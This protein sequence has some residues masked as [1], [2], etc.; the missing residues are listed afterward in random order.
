MQWGGKPRLWNLMVAEATWCFTVP[1]SL[2]LCVLKWFV[3]RMKSFKVCSHINSD[4][5]WIQILFGNLLCVTIGFCLHRKE[6]L[7]GD[8]I[9][10][11]SYWIQLFL[12][13]PLFVKLW[14]Q[15]ALDFQGLMCLSFQ[16]FCCHLSVILLSCLRDE[17]N[18]LIMVLA[19][20]LE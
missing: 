10:Q 13:F 11:S 15:P 7:S 16:F 8:P 12:S 9:S 20:S 19:C 1:C 2:L 17:Q 14:K 18:P 6:W 3:I 5:S 4:M